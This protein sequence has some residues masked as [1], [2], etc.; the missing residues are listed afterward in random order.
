MSA[1]LLSLI[2]GA[3]VAATPITP[4][5]WFEFTDYPMKAF[6]RNAEGV[7]RFEMLISPEGRVAGCT[8]ISSSG[9]EELDRASCFLSTKRAKFRPARNLDGQPVWG[10]FRTQAL[11]ALPEHHIVAPPAPDL[12][13]SLNALPDGTKQPPAVKLAYAVDRQGKPDLAS[14]TMMPS[15][16]QQPQLLVQLGCK[17]LLE[18]TPQTP[19]T[20]PSGQP[21]AAVKTGA[22]LFKTSG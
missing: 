21:V 9:D 12:E 2:S 16:L 11:W 7:T 22:V 8:V 10:T 14:C 20:D 13:V 17:Q 3:V 19:V 6:E 15:S 5:P 1:F 4:Q 18:S